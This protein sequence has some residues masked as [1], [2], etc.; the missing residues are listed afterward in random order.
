MCYGGSDPQGCW[1]EEGM[2][3]VGGGAVASRILVEDGSRE[4]DAAVREGI[5]VYSRRCGRLVFVKRRRDFEC[6]NMTVATV[7]VPWID[8]SMSQIRKGG[9]FPVIP[10]EMVFCISSPSPFLPPP[11]PLSFPPFFLS[12]F[13]LIRTHSPYQY[14]TEPSLHVS[15]ISQGHQE[16]SLLPHSHLV[17]PNPPAALDSRATNPTALA[18]G[19]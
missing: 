3:W 15:T 9:S 11:P 8:V 17:R 10:T 18:Y 2:A 4:H 14:V 19:F 12:L 13:S 5:R 6:C 7:S 16:A 1:R